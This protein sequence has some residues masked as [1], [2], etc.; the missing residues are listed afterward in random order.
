MAANGSFLA[1]SWQLI[2][3]SLAANGSVR[4]RNRQRFGS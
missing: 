2:G 1:T 3:G 4:G